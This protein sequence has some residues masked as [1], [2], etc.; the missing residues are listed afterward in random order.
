MPFALIIVIV[1]H[2]DGNAPAAFASGEDCD[3]PCHASYRSMG[4]ISDGVG[5]DLASY[6]GQGCDDGKQDADFAAV[7]E[8]HIDGSDWCKQQGRERDVR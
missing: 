5:S 8:R 6:G 4:C 2:L 1:A 3:V 7:I